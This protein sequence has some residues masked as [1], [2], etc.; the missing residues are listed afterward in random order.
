MTFSYYVPI[1]P[2]IPLEIR[3]LPPFEI[4]VLEM[5]KTWATYCLKEIDKF[6]MN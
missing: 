5:N 1:F 3:A 4:Y 6:A 2:P